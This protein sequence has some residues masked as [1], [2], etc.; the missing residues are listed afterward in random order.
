MAFNQVF[1]PFAFWLLSLL[2]NTQLDYPLVKQM[3]RKLIFKKLTPQ[4]QHAYLDLTNATSQ[5]TLDTL[6]AELMQ[7][8]LSLIS[9]KD[10]TSLCRSSKKLKNLVAPLLY[11][12]VEFDTPQDQHIFGD[13]TRRI[14]TTPLFHT[15]SLTFR[16]HWF[17]EFKVGYKE[18][19]PADV[20]CLPIWNR[21]HE[22]S[23]DNRLSDIIYAYNKLVRAAL[24]AIPKQQLNTFRSYSLFPVNGKIIEILLSQQNESLQQ[25]R[26]F[27][28][29]DAPNTSDCLPSMN[30]QAIECRS[31]EPDS[32]PVHENEELDGVIAFITN[33]IKT[34]SSTLRCLTIGHEAQIVRRNYSRRSPGFED[35]GAVLQA[36]VSMEML[37]SLSSLTLVGLNVDPTRWDLFSRS[38]E[39]SCLR[40]LTLEWCAGSAE[41]VQ[42]LAAAVT[43]NDQAERIQ[44]SI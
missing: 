3:K 2:T 12:V 35:E 41:L 25:L 24:K 26:L 23:G 42:Q 15:K 22:A 40:K 21:G 32:W 14:Y 31:L 9:H 18:L 38:V 36:L 1:A 10:S 17:D 34:N 11:R 43:T 27:R 13:F 8:V 44:L 37:L 19:V 28:L 6:P 5:L 29:S 4:T 7:T 20:G 39:L 33:L 30:L 16:N